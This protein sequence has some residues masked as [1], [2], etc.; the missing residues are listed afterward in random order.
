MILP[1]RLHPYLRAYRLRLFLGALC[2]AGSVAASLVKPHVIGQAI[3]AVAGK[4]VTPSVVTHLVLLLLG[5]AAVEAV[6]LYL[7]RWVLIGTSRL[8]ELDMRNDFYA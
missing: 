1:T 4:A 6:F 8:I 2:V 5:A 3:D 7:Q